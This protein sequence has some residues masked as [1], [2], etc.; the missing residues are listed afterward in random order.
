MMVLVFAETRMGRILDVSLELL[1]KGKE[2]SSKLGREL[3]AFIIG[4]EEQGRK[5]I[6][7]GAEK[8]Y[9]VRDERLE[10]YQPDVYSGLLKDL[11]DEIKPEIVLFG[12]TTIGGDLAATVAAKLETGLTAHCV[13]LRIDEEGR[14]VQVVPGFGGNIMVEN[15]CPN[16]RPQ[17]ATIRAGVFK[18]PERNDSAKG[19]IIRMEK[20]IKEEIFR[21]K[22]LEI[23]EEKPEGIPLEG[24]EII[25]AGGWGLRSAGFNLVKELAEVLG[26]AIGGTRPAVD[27]GWITEEEMIG[28]S[29]KIVRP[30]LY[31]GIG[32]SGAMHHTVGI[33]D[34][35]IIVSI[36]KSEDAPIFDISD[37]CIV[38]DAKEIVPRMVEELREGR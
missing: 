33:L 13:D 29:G 8:V 35:E 16:R 14:L 4:N 17:M 23:H 15:I 24:A 38:G 6:E 22:T 3:S 9:L 12:A 26:A 11:I 5:L 31:I 21:T 2:L 30:R 28:Q 7:Y 27:E 19:E 32:I 10:L 20:E 37:L 34:S 1:G 18:K 36:N 25:V